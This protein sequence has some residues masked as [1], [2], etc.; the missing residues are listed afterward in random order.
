MRETTNFGPY[1][2]RREELGGQIT[3][4]RTA[5]EPAFVG[6]QTELRSL[7]DDWDKMNSDPR[8]RMLGTIF[9]EIVVA[10]EAVSELA[11]RQGWRPYLRAALQKPRVLSERKTGVKRAEVVTSRVVRDEGGWLQL[12][13]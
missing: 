6:Q 3:G 12:A 10:G 4:L 5:S 8:K 1:L 9:E 2:R 11:P 13:G 7:V